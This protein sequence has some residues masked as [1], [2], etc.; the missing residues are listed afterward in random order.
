MNARRMIVQAV[1]WV[2]I[3]TVVLLNVGFVILVVHLIQK[4]RA[5][6]FSD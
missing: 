5:G 1:R 4:W 6:G 2:F 3:G